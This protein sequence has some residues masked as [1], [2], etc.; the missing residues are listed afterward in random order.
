MKRYRLYYQ[1]GAR[2]HKMCGRYKDGQYN[3]IVPSCGYDELIDA[4]LMAKHFKSI[5]FTNHQICILDFEQ[6][7]RGIIVDIL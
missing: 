6:K 7:Q 2:F 1:Q 4:K 3:I 5:G